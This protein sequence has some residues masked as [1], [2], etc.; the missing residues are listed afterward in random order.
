[1][2]RIE[3]GRKRQG[4]VP[5][6]LVREPSEGAADGLL[7]L[8]EEKVITCCPTRYPRN[9]RAVTKAVN[10]RASLLPGE[11]TSHAKKVDREYGGVPEGVVG[12]VQAKL[13][14]YPPLRGWVFGAWGEAS[15]DVHQMVDDLAEAR[16]KHQQ[17]L[18]GGN[19]RAR[20]L[21][22]EAE[23]AMLKGQVRRALSL[24]AVRSQ[25]RLL[26][27]RL[28]GIGGGADEAA[29]RRIRWAEEEER[30]MGRMRRAHQL[31]LFQGRPIRARGQFFLQQD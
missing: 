1:M 17:L 24:V 10:R 29:R 15:D 5:D 2:A 13:A 27:D 21:G 8:A 4:L 20:R 12:P 30:R 31:A 23:L 3:V 19:W 7:V 9:P 28:R 6:F 22:E 26:L 25:A 11:Y 14:S 16:Q 18:D